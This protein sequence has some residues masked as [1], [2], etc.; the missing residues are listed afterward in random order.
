MSQ[1]N[2]QRDSTEVDLDKLGPPQRGRYYERYWA[3]MATRTLEPDLAEQFPDSE[4]V[5]NAL[6]EYLQSKR[7]SA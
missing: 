2:D 3:H 7:E 1:E 6:R 5:N 4:S